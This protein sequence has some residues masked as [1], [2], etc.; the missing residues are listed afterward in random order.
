MGGRGTNSGGA[1]GGLT[2]GQ[3]GDTR[4]LISER[5]GSRTEVDDTLNV[6]RDV[7]SEYGLQIDTV[8]AELSPSAQNV[9]GYYSSNGDLGINE[10]YF[11]N[12]ALNDAYDKSVSMGFHPGRGNKSGMEAVVAHEAGHALTEEAGRRAGLGDWQL[13]SV[14]NDIVG[15]VA[16]KQGISTSSVRERVSGYAK[17][18]NAE[19][20]AEAYSDVY[21]NGDRA[22]SVSKD[23]VSTLNSD[24]FGR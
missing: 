3:I 7:Q 5:E 21:C 20:V 19:A 12:A 16:R 2:L 17:K 8:V 14:S 24:Y 1:S 13:D 15:K 22:S 4:S 23:I 9:M 6:L 10:T 18:S 11:N